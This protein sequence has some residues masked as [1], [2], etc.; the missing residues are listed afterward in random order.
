MRKCLRFMG[1][2][3]LQGQCATFPFAAADLLAN[4]YLG[5]CRDRGGSFVSSQRCLFC[6]LMALL[7]PDIGDACR[8]ANLQ[9]SIQKRE[10]WPAGYPAD[11]ACR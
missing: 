7:S 4:H 5:R 6:D 11:R 8:P 9:Y 1:E 3:L 10:V 2:V